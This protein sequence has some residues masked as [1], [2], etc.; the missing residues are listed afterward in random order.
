MAE[1][2]IP[3]SA[4]SLG[5]AEIFSLEFLEE[6]RLALE[7]AGG[8]RDMDRFDP[9]LPAG[10]AYAIR[11]STR[12]TSY[13]KR[14]QRKAA[15]D[16]TPHEVID[17]LNSAGVKDWVLMGLHGYVGYM[18]DPRATQDVNIMLPYSHRAR[19]KKA[20]VARWPELVVREL[21][22]VTRF[23]DPLDL[24]PNGQPKPA[25]DLMHPWSPFQE[26]ILKEYVIVDKEYV[27]VDKETQH[28]LPTLE[29]ALASKYAAMISPHRDRDKREYDA[30]DFRR[31]V[32]SNR[33]RIRND[34]LRRLAVLIW[35]RGGEEI[36]QFIRTALS[37]AA[38]P[39]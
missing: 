6:R 17:T 10:H 36:D 25:I 35:E 31:L 18:P 3:D 39:I 4:A 32:R 20:I 5:N 22:Q 9:T 37:D 28:R 7:Q 13:T 12:L 21:S 16:I 34:D 11:T 38:F 2:S 33:D 19:A 23:M 24:D 14:H 29:A 30:A 8:P 15:T 1:S 26:L 27:I